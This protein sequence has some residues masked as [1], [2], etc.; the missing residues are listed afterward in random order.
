[1]N[2]LLDWMSIGMCLGIVFYLLYILSSNILILPI[3]SV[4]AVCLGIGTFSYF[5]FWVWH[6]MSLSKTMS[7][8]ERWNNG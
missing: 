7:R 3:E 6:K 5:A 8:K 4:F 2:N 1:M